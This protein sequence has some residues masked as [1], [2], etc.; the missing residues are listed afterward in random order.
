MHIIKRFETFTDEE[1]IKRINDGE[2]ELFEIIIRRNNPYL[3]KIGRSYG[4]NHQDVED[5]MQETFISVFMNLTK[6]EFR[7][8]LKTWITRIM[9][10]QCY[11]RCQRASFKNE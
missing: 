10:N 11:Q 6:F 2:T 4:F 7:S 3:Y 8:S 1:L 9:I 5:L